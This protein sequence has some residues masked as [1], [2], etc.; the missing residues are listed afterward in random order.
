MLKIFDFL[1]PGLLEQPLIQLET[2]ITASVLLALWFSQRAR[3]AL[4]PTGRLLEMLGGHPRRLIALSGVCALAIHALVSIGQPPRE[5]EIHDEFSYW[6][7]ADTFLHGRAANPPSPLFR[8]FE[9]AHVLQ[10]PS[11]ASMYP[12][13]QG[14]LL[15]SGKLLTGHFLGGLWIAGALMGPLAGWM[16]LAWMPRRWAAFGAV[17]VAL[18]YSIFSYW[19][20]SYWGGLVPALGGILLLG[21][22]PRWFRTRSPVHGIGIAAALLL[23]ANSR[24]YETLVLSLALAPVVFVLARRRGGWRASL[25]PALAPAVVLLCAGAGAM[26]WYNMQVTGNPLK[27]GYQLYMSNWGLAVLPWQ[28]A[29]PADPPASKILQEFLETQRERFQSQTTLPGF[30]ANRLVALDKFWLFYVGPLL[31]LP[32][33]GILGLKGRF[34]ILMLS[35]GLYALGLALNPW[36]FAHYF[37]PAFG[38]LVILLM[39]SIRRLAQ[40]RFGKAA[41]GSLLAICMFMVGVRCVA[42]P[43]WLPTPQNQF[44]PTWFQTTAGGVKRHAVEIKLAREPGS[45]LV[46]VRYPEGHDSYIEWVYNGADLDAA[47]VIWARWLDARSNQ[48]L[49]DRYRGRRVWIAEPRTTGS[50]LEPLEP[51]GTTQ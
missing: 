4:A 18:R 13:M 5:P 48:N 39:E 37:A 32:V 28:S 24:P 22:L 47:K 40:M 12:P 17:M 41:A 38:L 35:L 6:L 49:L 9:T 10:R 43:A 1:V 21:A 34:R 19:T 30:I 3:M 36:F 42:G 44:Y 46:L 16:L 29:V 11:Y 31:T 27:M 45:H 26:L 33:L 20:N 23:L 14:L 8:S 7:S 15:A 25:C 2:A 51:R 50:L